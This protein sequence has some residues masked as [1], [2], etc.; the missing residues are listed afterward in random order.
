M[1]LVIFNTKTFIK[2]FLPHQKI[3]YLQSLNAKDTNKNLLENNKPKNIYHYET[4]FKFA[5]CVEQGSGA[6]LSPPYGSRTF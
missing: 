2:C 4:E 5:D 3:V 6:V 1:S